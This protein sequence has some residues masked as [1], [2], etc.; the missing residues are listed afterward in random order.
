MRID[1]KAIKAHAMRGL[2]VFAASR[3]IA[4]HGGLAAGNPDHPGGLLRRYA[5]KGERD[6]EYEIKVHYNRKRSSPVPKLDEC[7][8]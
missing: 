8:N 6:S 5:V 3:L 7:Y 4:A 1:P 2:L